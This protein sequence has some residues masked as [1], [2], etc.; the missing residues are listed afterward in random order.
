MRAGIDEM[1]V[2]Y[3][4]F[5]T[6]QVYFALGSFPLRYY[7]FKRQYIV[8]VKQTWFIQ[9]NKMILFE[10]AEH[11]LLTLLVKDDTSPNLTE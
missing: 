9:C 10:R 2:V 7:N 4:K 5:K 8:V 11:L 6:V 3:L 1:L